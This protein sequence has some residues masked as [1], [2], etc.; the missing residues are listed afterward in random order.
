MKKFL[1]SFLLATLIMIPAELFAADF[2]TPHTFS[3]G[4]TISAD[5]MNEIFNYIKNKNKKLTVDDLT[6]TWSCKKYMLNYGSSCLV[7]FSLS[8]GMYY[9]DNIQTTITK[10][11][12]STAETGFKVLRKDSLTGSYSTVTTT[13]ADATTYSDTV[14]A[15]GN[16]WYRVS[17]INSNGDSVGS[18]VVKVD[19]E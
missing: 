12:N 18:K 7:N 5:M 15:A 4:D 6:G 10:S 9:R 17:A 13:S 19:V 16:F 3:A 1:I 8:N 14:T 2:E 11:D